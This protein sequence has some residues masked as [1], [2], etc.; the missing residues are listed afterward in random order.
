VVLL[1]ILVY[2]LQGS[3]V[4]CTTSIIICIG[5]FTDKGCATRKEKTILNE[6]AKWAKRYSCHA[7][8]PV[9]LLVI[10]PNSAAYRYRCSSKF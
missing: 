8:V 7:E 5:Y 9:T 6:L 10:F 1:P 3:I 4:L 2:R